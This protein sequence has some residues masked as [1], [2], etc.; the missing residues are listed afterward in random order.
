MAYWRKLIPVMLVALTA[1]ACV[2]ADMVPTTGSGV[3]CGCAMPVDGSA[4]TPSANATET[5]LD[6]G[7]VDLDL[8]PTATA[9]PDA[10]ADETTS[11]DVVVLDRDRGSLEWCLYALM[12]VGLCKSAPL[13]R[14]ISIGFVPEWYHTGAPLQIGASHAVGPDCLCNAAV[15]FVQPDSPNTDSTH[16]LGFVAIT[17]RSLSSQCALA[18][19]PSR[20]PPSIS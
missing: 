19:H 8:F 6:L 1:T 4:I 17:P 2:H 5:S 20:G 13:F 11:Q 14:K 7:V 12:G 16:R 15:C 9:L 10:T 3:S 18:A